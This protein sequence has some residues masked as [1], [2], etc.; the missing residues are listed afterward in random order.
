[1]TGPG[2]TPKGGRD[3]GGVTALPVLESSFDDFEAGRAGGAGDKGDLDL[4][5]AAEHVEAGGGCGKR[6]RDVERRAQAERLLRGAEGVEHARA[7]EAAG[8]DPGGAAVG[9][10]GDETC[11]AIDG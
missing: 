7:F 3:G 10:L 5:L 9:P 8:A 6:R 11:E 2:G 4:A 1:M